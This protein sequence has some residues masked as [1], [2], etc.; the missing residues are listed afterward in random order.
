MLWMALLGP[1]S[2]THWTLVL[3][4]PAVARGSRG[5][6]VKRAE[7]ALMLPLHYSSFV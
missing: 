3:S 7:F 4:K 5:G 6:E 2:A 1:T